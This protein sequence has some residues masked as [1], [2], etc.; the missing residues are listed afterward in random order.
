[1]KKILLLILVLLFTKPIFPQNNLQFLSATTGAAC[2]AIKYYNGYVLTGTGST[3]RSYYVGAGV[4]F[5]YGFEYRYESQIIRMSIKDHFLFVCANYDGLTKWDISNPANPVKIYDLLPDSAGM[6][7]QGI[8]FKGDTLFIAQLSKVSVY[9]DNGSSFSK[10][11]DFGYAQPSAWSVTGVDAKGNLCAYTVFSVWPNKNGVYLYNS[12]SFSFISYYQ[13]TFCY[14]ENVIWGKNNNLLHVMGGTNSTNGYFYTLNVSNPASPQKIFADTV[15][16]APF[17]LAMALPYNAENHNDT[18]YVATWGGLKPNAGF[19]YCYMRVYDATNPANVHLLTY[20]PAGL[21]HFDMTIHHPYIY[22]ASEWYGIKTFN[23]SDIMNPVDMGNTVTGGWNHYADNFGNWLAVSNEGYGFKLYDITNPMNP[24]LYDT[25][26]Y[27]GFCFRTKFSADGEYIFACYGTYHGM[28]VFRRDGLEKISI[29]QQAVCKQRFELYQDRIYSQLDNKINIIDVAD[30]YNPAVDTS[31]TFTINDMMVSNGILYISNNT[32]IYAMNITNHNFQQVASVTLAG[33]QDATALT[34]YNNEL[35]VFVSNKGLVKY[36][37]NFDGFTYSFVEDTY[38]ALTNGVPNF[39]A[40]DTFGVYLSY[41]T[42]GLFALNRQTL[43]QTGYYR[44]GLD[45]RL[46]TDQ[47]GVQNLFCKNNLIFLSE[48]QCQTSILSNDNNFSSVP[49]TKTNYAEE[50]VTIYPNPSGSSVKISIN[51]EIIGNNF[52]YKIY[53]ATGKIIKSQILNLKSQIIL[54]GLNSGLYFLEII[55]DKKI[56][57][58]K[59]FVVGV[60][61]F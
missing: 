6:A 47:Y 21:W 19:N 12:N 36:H 7:T 20:I 17:G 46:Y 23:I 3:L 4:P 61:A 44:T 56:I 59:K 22:V 54:I 33:N 32:G 10:I 35:F 9:K 30:P 2:H 45:Y 58:A 55:S 41:R 14:S 26:Q 52:E 5:N 38:I 27:K 39:M 57:A 16:G 18:L 53:D 40:A 15:L 43:A 51:S 34:A 42:K 24:V 31:I 11:A 28:R 25:S 13:Q 37:L 29:I 8:A 50:L 60:R 48:Y 1:M 49:E